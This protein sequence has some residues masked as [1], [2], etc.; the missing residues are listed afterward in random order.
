[1]TRPMTRRDRLMATLRGGAVDRPP[2][3]LYEIGGLQMDPTD[4]DPYNVYRDPTWRPLLE[5]AEGETDLIRMRS[6]VRAQSHVAWDQS[7]P[8]GA[9]SV[10]D[11]LMQTESWERDG[12]R[13]TRVTVQIG[14]RLLTCQMRREKDVDTLWTVEHLLKDRDDLLAYLQL[15]D[16][17]F[18]EPIAVGPLSAEEQS[19]GDRGIVMVDTEDPLCAAATLFS[20]QD[21]T[22]VAFTERALFH[23]LLQKLAGPLQRRTEQVARAFPGRLWRIYGPE[24]C[25][26]PYLPPRLFKE[27]VVRYTAPMVKAI[28]SKGGYARIH[29]HGRLRAILPLLAEMGASGL[30]PIEPP[31]QGDV[32]LAEVRRDYGAGWVLFG[33]LEASDIE[34]QEPAAFEKTVR[35][36]LAEGTAGKG[37]G[38]VLMPSASPYGRTITPRTMANYET[39]VRLVG[40]FGG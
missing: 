2:V 25:A 4:P 21:Y 28:Q 14:G 1:M 7:S 9:R 3:S 15:P 8:S 35:R 30:D 24:Y 18:D 20:M 16:E 39:M 10:R 19:V 29:C 27:Y 37:R 22:I 31:Q 17:F 6:A 11:E 5:L 33:N 34:N 23:R 38:F 36:A 40:E 26:E 13:H 12:C 32:S